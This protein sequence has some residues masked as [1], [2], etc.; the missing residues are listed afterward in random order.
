MS[1]QDVVL[2]FFLLFSHH[3]ENTVQVLLESLEDAARVLSSSI[4]TNEVVEALGERCIWD[5]GSLEVMMVDV[6]HAVLRMDSHCLWEHVDELNKQLLSLRGCGVIDEN[7]SVG[8]L[9]DWAI[10]LLVLQISADVP[11]LDVDPSE[12]SHRCRRFTL[13]IDNPKKKQLESS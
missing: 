12:V 6:D 7:N 8:I 4:V 13:E 11:E 1:C 2:L 3:L 5:A 10:A 9:L